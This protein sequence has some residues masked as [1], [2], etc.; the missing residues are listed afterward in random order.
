MSHGILKTALL[1]HTLELEY[2]PLIDDESSA[3]PIPSAAVMSSQP[4]ATLA[5][6][7]AQL[8]SVI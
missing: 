7:F 5:E 1:N 6:E 3:D 4:V 2:R 8:L